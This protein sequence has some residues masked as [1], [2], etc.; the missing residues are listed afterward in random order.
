MSGR[1]SIEVSK[2]IVRNSVLHSLA[3]SS[4]D[5]RFA[6]SV[7]GF[8]QILQGGKFTG[9]WRYDEALTLA[10]SARGNDPHGYRSEFV[11]LIELAQSLSSV[12]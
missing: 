11:H 3:S 6:A 4:A 2:I 12:T 7:A 5:L 10:R 8:G 9:N 1:S